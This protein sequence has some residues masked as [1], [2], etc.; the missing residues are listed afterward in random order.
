MLPFT[1]SDAVQSVLII[2]AFLIAGK[3]FTWFAQSIV[4]R[5]AARTKTDIDDL[6]VAKVK[7]PFSYIVWFLGIRVALEPLN[8]NIPVLDKI[9]STVIVGIIFYIIAA[10]VDIFVKSALHRISAKTQSTLDDTL[11][12]LINKTINVVV[13]LIG[14]MWI[15]RVWDID[16]T[17][18]IASLGVAGLAIG[19]AVKDSLANIFGGISLILDQ[20]VAVGDKV[21]LESGEMG[22]I[23]D[24]GLRS[25][26]L[27]TPDNELIIVPNGQLAN[28][29]VQN[30]AQPTLTQR[31]V[32]DFGVGYDSDVDAVRKAVYEALLT[33]DGVSTDDKM[34][35][36]L[37]MSMEDF[38]LRFSA[39]FWV[40][41]YGDAF[42]SKIDAT[43]KIFTALK[44]H[45]IDIPFPTH[46]VKME[47]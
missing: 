7:P 19:L 25:T 1:T 16:I 21:K 39:R 10:V 34:P 31:V 30:F 40:D 4:T 32:I 9:L 45:K 33:V 17:P 3:L 44:K 26:R 24:V 43:D 46:T 15:L 2:I 22:H 13:I 23:E 27:R 5:W 28:S 18:L 11:M 41:N 36:V 14:V 20:T 37:F 12:P 47:K 29:R 35:E 8:L 6:I 42:R 38:Y